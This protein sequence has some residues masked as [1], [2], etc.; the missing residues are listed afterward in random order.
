[1]FLKFRVGVRLAQQQL[2]QPVRHNMEGHTAE[3]YTE[4]VSLSVRLLEQH[5]SVMKEKYGTE[6]LNEAQDR[7][8]VIALVESWKAGLTTVVDIEESPEIL[9]TSPEEEM[10]IA[11][12]NNAADNQAMAEDTESDLNIEVPHAAN[13]PDS[14][15]GST[16]A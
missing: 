7:N 12:E 3:D 13:A 4:R 16:A 5:E 14:R 11:S 1:M 2:R 15:S 6:Y 10:V 8:D 9:S